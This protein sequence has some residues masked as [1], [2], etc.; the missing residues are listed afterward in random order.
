MKR[1]LLVLALLALA[2]CAKRT[3]DL[4]FV[5]VKHDDLTIGVEISGELEAVDS[6]D[7]HPPSIGQIWNFKI[8]QIAGDGDDV[9]A[10][11]AGRRV[12]SVAS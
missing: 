5:D 9:K 3:G 12:R 10:G 8:A 11:R 1:W 2:S 7:I 6:T 4:Q